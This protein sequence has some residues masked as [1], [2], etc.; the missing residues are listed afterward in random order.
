M[1]PSIVNLTLELSQ[2]G[3]AGIS[4]NASTYGGGRI[5]LV[6]DSAQLEG[7]GAKI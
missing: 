5:V 6:S 4:N 2:T 1:R 7:P 3:S